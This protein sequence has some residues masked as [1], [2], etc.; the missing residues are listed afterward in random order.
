M[1]VVKN[2]QSVEE[3]YG[4][5]YVVHFELEGKSLVK[6][7]VTARS[8]EERVSEILVSIFKIYREFPYCRP[9]RFRKTSEVYEKEARLHKYF[10][11]YRYVTQHPFSGSTEFFDVPL[12]EVV[13]IYEQLLDGKLDESMQSQSNDAG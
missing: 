1:K 10:D 9:K 8:I 12:D 4:I 3:D 11:T 6:I 7:G 2:K 5:L 13:N